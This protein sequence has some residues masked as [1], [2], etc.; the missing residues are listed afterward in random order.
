[1]HIEND[2]IA[3][4]ALTQNRGETVQLAKFINVAPQA[5]SGWKQY[6]IPARWRPTIWALLETRCPDVAAKLDRDTFLGVH[7]TGDAA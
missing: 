2:K 6:G 7:L 1:M 5:I 4:A 3:M